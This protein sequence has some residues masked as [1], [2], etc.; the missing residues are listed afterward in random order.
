MWL[1]YKMTS[2]VQNKYKY[3]AKI[4]KYCQLFQFFGIF[5]EQIGQKMH[6]TGFEPVTFASGVQNQQSALYGLPSIHPLKASI[7]LSKLLMLSK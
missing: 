5:F 3:W 6:P 2:F 7:A 1:G 4:H